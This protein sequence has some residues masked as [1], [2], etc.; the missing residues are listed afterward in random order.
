[1][2]D[3][4]HDAQ[5]RL[6]GTI[7][8]LGRLPII[9]SS[10]YTDYVNG[11]EEIFLRYSCCVGT[12]AS[13]SCML[14]DKR[15]NIASPPLGYVPITLNGRATCVY[16][17]RQPARKQQQG[18]SPHRLFVFPNGSEGRPTRNN[19]TNKQIGTGILGK[20]N[21]P[22]MYE[23]LAY[24]LEHY[25]S[26]VIFSRDIACSWRHVY[27]KA[28]VIGTIRHEENRHIISIS[29]STFKRYNFEGIFDENWRVD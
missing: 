14:S 25:D 22:K 18:I 20:F 8:R 6:E 2:Y 10:L 11:K 7:I 28:H 9:I 15:V 23:K 3:N 19:L 24:D 13:G 5:M 12:E 21:G 27:Y 29:S 16:A 26:D 1:M 4:L 17:V